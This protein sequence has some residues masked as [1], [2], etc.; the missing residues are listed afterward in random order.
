MP[1]KI[2]E[3]EH[4]D[5]IKKIKAIVTADDLINL[6][7]KKC[8]RYIGFIS[9]I[10]TIKNIKLSRKFFKP[11]AY[12]GYTLQKNSIAIVQSHPNAIP[13]LFA[14][15]ENGVIK[16]SLK[17][18]LSALEMSLEAKKKS[19]PVILFFGGSTIMGDGS[20]LPEYSIPAQVKKRLFEDFSTKSCCINFGVSG[21]SSQDCANLLNA[22]LIQEY[23]PDL[24]IFYD[25][26]NCYNHFSTMNCIN[27]STILNENYEQ[28]SSQGFYSFVHNYYLNKSY[29]FLWQ[30]KYLFVL[31]AINILSILIDLSKSKYLKNYLIK[32]INNLSPEA[33]PSYI[34]NILQKYLPG[35]EKTKKE[36]SNLSAKKYIG[37]HQDVEKLCLSNKVQ[38]ITCLQPLLFLSKKPHSVEEKTIS[39]NQDLVGIKAFYDNLSSFFLSK[40]N[41]FNLGSIF[42]ETHD[43]VYVDSGHLNAY[44]NYTVAGELSK[45]IHLNLSGKPTGEHP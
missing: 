14:T 27:L 10:P 5:W 23:Q 41:Y 2:Q 29:N 21:Y 24:I 7:D 40:S 38:F 4:E 1:K 11:N 37:I 16:N 9:G 26:W 18:P 42:D 33:G 39:N 22:K 44:G 15:D 13:N 35:E 45:I 3:N 20:A 36:I 12:Y 28:Y 31:G 32:K 8:A 34:L 43:H 17:C 19:E 6:I 25:G 30:A